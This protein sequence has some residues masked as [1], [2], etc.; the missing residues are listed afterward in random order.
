MKRA[1]ITGINGMDGSH[2]ADFLLKKGYNVFGMERR[3]SSKNRTN[4]AHLEDKI[5]FINGDIMEAV[6]ADSLLKP[7]AFEL[8]VS[9]P[10]N[11]VGNGYTAYCH[12]FNNDVQANIQ[13]LAGHHPQ[14]RAMVALAQAEFAANKLI[15]A[16]D[17]EPVYLRNPV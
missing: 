8:P 12:D 3:S 13:L 16:Q 6:M 14:A 11:V 10:F 7:K 2:L 1:L 9:R 15:S 5:T 17:L 4:T